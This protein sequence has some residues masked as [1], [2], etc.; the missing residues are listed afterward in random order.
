MHKET[1]LGK[2]YP[3]QKGGLRVKKRILIIGSLNMDMVIEMQSMP[4]VGETVLARTLTYI[5]GGKGANQ[6]CAAG[7][8]GGSVRM[9]GCVGDD[10]LGETLLENLAA[11]GADVSCVRK[12]EG[13]TTG[14]AVIYVSSE[15]DNSIVVV[16]GANSSCSIDYLKSYD[17]LFEEADY[18]MLQMEIPYDSVFYAVRRAAELGKTVVLNPAPAPQP[19]EIPEDIWEKI[20]YLTPN[21]TELMKLSRMDSIGM[22]QIEKGAKELRR[23]GVK[24]VLVTLGDKG[25]YFYNGN[26]TLF[27]ARAVEAV[28]TTAAGDCFNGAFVTALAEGKTVAESVRLANTASSLAVT[29]KGAQSSI[30]SR[31]EVRKILEEEQNGAM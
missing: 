27:P 5:P 12:E 26:G 20:D 8:L 6:T 19:E 11:S 7:K 4:K 3:I 14:I 13:Q 17:A 23:K 18:V 16:S 2:R 10:S 9:L 30:P 22:E 21:E 25:V 29:R 28:D 15:G 24:N 1:S 31:E